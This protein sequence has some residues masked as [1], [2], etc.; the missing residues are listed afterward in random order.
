MGET[1][2]IGRD[3]LALMRLESDAV[4]AAHPELRGPYA[5]PPPPVK[6]PV[7]EAEFVPVPVLTAGQK[8]EAF[9]LD[10]LTPDPVPALQVQAM[11]EAAGI[12][13]RTLRRVAKRIG[14]V[15]VKQG[16]GGWAWRLE[17]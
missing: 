10:A 15:K 7:V 2:Y 5:V 6:S 12:A 9:L 17:R 3:R 1:F 11:A 16:R 8:A 14:I 4:L 13:L